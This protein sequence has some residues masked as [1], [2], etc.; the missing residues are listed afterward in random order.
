MLRRVRT[1]APLTAR[2]AEAGCAPTARLGEPGVPPGDGPRS[3]DMCGLRTA[4]GARGRLTRVQRRHHYELAF[5]TLLRDR[6][7]PYVAVDEARKAL[8][9]EDAPLAAAR[10]PGEPMSALKSFDFVVYA[11]GSARADGNLLVDVKGRKVPR[12][13][14]GTPPPTRS[15]LQNWV[16]LDDVESL[17]TW[18][19]L[20]GEG[21]RA[22]FVFV[23]WCDDQ[24]PDG[25]FQE[26]FEHR[27]RWYAVRVIALDDYR[28]A[29]RPRSR[30]WSTVHLPTDAFERL[31][32]PFPPREPG[33]RSRV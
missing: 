3:T 6:R 23:Y 10:A 19:G 29:M 31:S 26:V 17:G 33:G 22:A 14:G 4:P 5:Q 18:Q 28:R 21:F 20:F 13:A 2:C 32:Q 30:R 15:R 24:P 11:D 16:T 9:P 7:I 25:L 8:L 12:S 27:G 1:D